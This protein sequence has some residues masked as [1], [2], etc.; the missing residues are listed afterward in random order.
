MA[1]SRSTVWRT[2]RSTATPVTFALSGAWA[3]LEAL[4]DAKT[5]GMSGKDRIAVL[6]DEIERERTDVT[7]R[8]IRGPAYFA[9]R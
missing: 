9:R 5:T 4:T 2:S 3:I 1:R 7:M 8:S 6:E